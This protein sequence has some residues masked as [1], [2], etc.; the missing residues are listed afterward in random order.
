[1][2]NKDLRVEKTEQALLN[3]LF[4]TLR[5]KDFGQIT[6]QDLCDKAL[7]RRST[8]YRRF[9]DK[10][11]LLK[12][13]IQKL[14]FRVREKHSTTL[15]PDD[16]RPHFEK[17]IRESLDYL[18]EHKPIVQNVLT[19]ALYDEVTDIIYEQLYEGMKA[20]IQFEIRHGVEFNVDIDILADFIAGGILRTMYAWIQ[21]GQE[22]SID[23]LTKEVVTI[24]NG[25]H[26]Y[27]CLLYTSDAADE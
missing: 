14:I 9:D 4:E 15:N 27:H 23:D 13:L 25:V 3:A 5:T 21:D 17:V 1:M 19:M 18:Y 6:V 10:Y 20:Q 22:R 11:D 16:P 2:K 8:F 26:N 7:V 12:L 24:L